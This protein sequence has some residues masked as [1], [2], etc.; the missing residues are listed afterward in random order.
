MANPI[1]RN[2]LVSSICVHIEIQSRVRVDDATVMEYVEAW[3]AGAD[4]PAIDVFHSDDRIHYLADGF[5]RLLGAK[6]AGELS[7]PSR[8]HKGSARDAFLFACTANQTHGLRRTNADKR[9]M[10]TRFLSD[11]E[12]AKWSD[13]RIAEQCGVSQTFV[14]SL[15]SQVT[16]VVTSN[17]ADDLPVPRVGIDG[18]HYLPAR[19]RANAADQVQ[20]ELSIARVSFTPQK[21]RA[22]L[23]ALKQ[24]ETYLQVVGR[25]SEYFA[26]ALKSIE[27]ELRYETESSTDIESHP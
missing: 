10:V 26:V 24:V 19:S 12:W 18:K 15:R 1:L 4:F 9:H 11:Q 14:S 2:L 27:K 20:P 3:K 17:S 21:R 5:H 6:K 23:Q 8:L 7:I 25:F 13:R 22:A 16:T